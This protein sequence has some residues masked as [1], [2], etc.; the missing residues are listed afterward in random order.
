MHS[1]QELSIPEHLNSNKTVRLVWHPSTK[2]Y[3]KFYISKECSTPNLSTFPTSSLQQFSYQ[4]I[5]PVKTWSGPPG[6]CFFFCMK[7]WNHWQC[8]QNERCISLRISDFISSCRSTNSLK[9][10]ICILDG[11]SWTNRFG[12]T[13]CF[14]KSQ[15]I[16]C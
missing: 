2:I 3:F 15:N 11:Y 9:V 10:W 5:W 12:T 13:L 6:F 7:W 16:T 1:S 4:A 14:L 8:Q